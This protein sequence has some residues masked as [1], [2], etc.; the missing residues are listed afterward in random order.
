MI[1]NRVNTV[2]IIGAGIFGV[3]TAVQLA[4]RGLQVTLLNDGPPANGASGRSLSWLN[5]SRMRSDAYHRLRM[6]GIDRYRTLAR[7]V[8]PVDWLSFEGGLTWDADDSSNEIEAAFHH[9]VSLAYDALHLGGD[10]VAAVTPGVDAAAITPQGAIFNPGEGWVDLPSLIQLL[11]EEFR[12]RGGRLV[13]DAGPARVLVEAG[14]AIGAET[15]SGARFPGEAVLLATGPSVP[16][17]VAE[18]GENIDDD[19]PVSLLVTT[20]PLSHPLKAVLNTPRVAIRPAPGNRFALDAGWS[21]E[22][23]ERRAD[24]TYGVKP[25]TVEGLLAEASRVLEGHPR[26]ELAGYGVG[27]KPI[28]GDGDPVFGELQA[29]PGYFVAFSHSGATLGLIAGELLAHEIAMGERHPMLA[30]FRPERFA[31]KG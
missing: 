16:Q 10:Q 2:V 12:S 21:E 1:E 11:L 17:M 29:I 25:E 31:R 24:G 20:K 8:G 15:A 5:S 28:P 9:E 27:K 14:R 3:S 22:E 13:T 30:P 18:A 4:R 6:A 19:T 23:V 26:L 7:R